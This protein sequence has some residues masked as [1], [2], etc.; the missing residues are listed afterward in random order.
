MSLAP[1]MFRLPRSERNR[2]ATETSRLPSEPASAQRPGSTVVPLE[3]VSSAVEMR[4]GR[5]AAVQ[6]SLRRCN[7]S[8][9]HPRY[10][11]SSSDT[12]GRLALRA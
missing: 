9:H 1:A 12:G 7:R 11:S 6:A 4:S 5:S 10:H 3:G 8:G 2:L